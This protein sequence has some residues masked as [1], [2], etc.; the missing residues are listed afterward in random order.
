MVTR[1]ARLLLC[2]LLLLASVSSLAL[3]APVALD[4]GTARLSMAGLMQASPRGVVYGDAEA[5][6]DAY[7]GGHFEPLPG[8]LGRG[9]RSDDVWLA[10]DLDLTDWPLEQ[11]IVEVGP[12]YLD[13]VTA[14]MTGHD[15]TLHRIGQAGDQVPRDSAPLPALKPA[16]ALTLH[17][18]ARSTVLLQIQTTSTQSALVTLY[19]PA[20][21]LDMAVGESLVLGGVF[22]VSL[23]LLLLTFAMYVLLRDPAYL[24]WLLYVAI[25]TSLWF[26]IDGLAYRFLS[27]QRL[28]WFNIATNALGALSLA[29]SLLVATFLFDFRQLSPL[30]H[31][32]FVTWP[33]LVLSAMGLGLLLDTMY[34][35]STLFLVS[36][37]LIGVA[38]LGIL[39]QMWRRQRLALLFG[40][41]H[42]IYT[43]MAVFNV[44]ANMGWLPVTL[45]SFYGWQIAGV[46]YL[47]ALQFA[48]FDRARQMQL[49]H[50]QARQQLLTQLADKNQELEERV[51][52]RTQEMQQALEQLRQAELEQRQ[53]LSMASHEF[54]T[55]AAMIKASLDS[56]QYLQSQITPEVATR[57]GNIRQAS[58]RMIRLTN[59][60]I[61][62]DRVRERSL[63]PSLKRIDL[64]EL[65]AGVTAQYTDAPWLRVQLPPAAVWIDADP[66]LLTIALN[67]LIDNAVRYGEGQTRGVQ[68]EL[69]SR[70]GEAVLRVADQGPGIPAADKSRVF[71]RFY[72]QSDSRP[73][74]EKTS[75]G[76]GLFIVQSIASSHRGTVH[77][78]DNSPRGSVF[79][80][81]LP[82]KERA[83][84]S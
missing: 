4:A 2:C 26:F 3:P 51:A 61:G 20:N 38:G 9:Y 76:L 19:Q 49:L 35:P 21:Y 53:L 33:L 52:V 27:L 66:A 14:Y 83:P 81:S 60:L 78:E 40:A 10:F 65:V 5:A 7:R 63:K 46:L 36:L 48:I 1:P 43:G 37:P 75:S 77:A 57:L 79:V 39:R 54:R 68:I 72:G 16:F 47:V 41:P 15:D 64:R 24:L 69:S 71:E 18:Q 44:V 80:V 58:Q 30:L 12:A 8:N 45:F 73:P 82:L 13:R 23:V 70:A 74:Q 50:A 17:G 55:P 25:T 56:L 34:V 11:L 29:M 22:M 59:D 6:L 62:Q 32:L 31:R 42:L 67:N 84:P 28:E